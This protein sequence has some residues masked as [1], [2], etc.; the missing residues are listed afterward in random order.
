VLHAIRVSIFIV[1]VLFFI[2]FSFIFLTFCIL[3]T[4]CVLLIVL[5]WILR[6][7]FSSL[8][9]DD[10]LEIVVVFFNLLDLLLGRGLVA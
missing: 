5:F 8:M 1:V 6:V 2:F 4:L 7:V 9:L 10:T 3:I